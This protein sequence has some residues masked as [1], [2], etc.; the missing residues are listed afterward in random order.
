MT[1]PDVTSLDP[2]AVRAALHRAQE[3]LW[4]TQRPDGSW[5]S[6]CDMGAIPTAQVL[7]AVHA[8]GALAPADAADGARWLRTRQEADGSYRSHPTATEGDLGA[9]A[10]AWAALSVCAPGE[11]GDAVARAR[12]WVDAHGGTP[13]VVAAFGRGDPAV[14]YLALAGLVEPSELPCPPMVPALIPRLVA[15]M[16]R[17]FHSGIMM[18]SGALTLIAHRLRGDWDPPSP[19]TRPTA[20]LSAC[21]RRRRAARPG[22]A[23]VYVSHAHAA[24]HVSEPRWQLERQHG[25]DGVDA[26]GVARRGPGHRPSDGGRRGGV[27]RVPACARR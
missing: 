3:V 24:V 18:V 23:T 14:V 26:A 13:E 19:P 6:L 12:G 15:F 5:E 21:G 20:R 25:A 10:S 16:E 27:A 22:R 9:T 2:G 4:Q 7:V 8:A 1:V 17:R 11:S